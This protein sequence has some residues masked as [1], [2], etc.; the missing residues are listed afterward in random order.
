MYILILNFI[1]AGQ[2]N[3]NTEIRFT[4]F[5]NEQPCESAAEILKT[6]WK[7]KVDGAKIL[8]ACVQYKSE[9]KA[10]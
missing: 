4:Q 10:K 1:V 6:K 2:F 8:T 9:K 5:G 3:T 7:D